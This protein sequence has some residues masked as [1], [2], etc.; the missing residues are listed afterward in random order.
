MNES[1][2]EGYMKK[3]TG[4][5]TVR[6]KYWNKQGV[7]DSAKHAPDIIELIKEYNLISPN[8]GGY[9]KEK[10]ELPLDISEKYNPQ[11]ACVLQA[12]ISVKGEVFGVKSSK[13]LHEVIFKKYQDFCQ[14]SED[15]VMLELFKNAGLTRIDI[16]EGD[17]T[18]EKLKAN[19]KVGKY[20]VTVKGSVEDHVVIWTR[21]KST[22]EWIEYKQTGG[23]GGYR[24]YKPSEQDKVLYLFKA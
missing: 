5:D 1:K 20:L 18:I 24:Q 9:G 16:S 8:V 2:L 10:K 11:K 4:L 15:S 13:D 23:G 21:E 7:F 14:Y 6:I 22:D 19:F 3:L 17:T 12:L